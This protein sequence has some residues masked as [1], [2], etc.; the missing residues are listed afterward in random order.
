MIDQQTVN[1]IIEFAE[2]TDVVQ[3]FVHLKRRGVNFLGLCPFHNEKTPSFTVSPSKGI[4]KCFGC[5]KAGNAVGFIMDH[6]QLSYPEALRYLAKKYHIEITE[7]ESSPEQIEQ[8]NHRDSMLVLSSFAQ[9]YFSNIL[10]NDREGKAI[11]LSYLKE[12]G[13]SDQIIEKFQLGYSPE[14]KSSFTDYAIKNGYQPKYLIDTGLTI[15][16]NDYRFD[17]FA[18]RVMFPIHALSGNTI[19]FGGRIL[20]IAENTAKYLNSPESEIY[21]KSDVLYGIYFAKRD[22]VKQDKCY[23]VEGYTDVISFHQAGI[24]N[25]V[26]SSG[27]S[28]TENQIRLVK[29]FTD[30]LTILYDGDPAGIKASF[31]GIDMVLE[32]GMNVKVVLFPDGEDPDSFSKKMGKKE[33]KDFIQENENDF[34]RFKTSLLLNEAK[35]DPIKKAGLISNIVRSIGVIPDAIIRSVYIKECSALLNVQEDALYAEI[36]RI[37]FQKRETDRKQQ[38]SNTQQQLKQSQSKALPGFIEDVYAEINEKEIISFLI[39]YGDKEL[40][41]QTGNDPFSEQSVTVA[42][43]IIDEILNDDLEFKNLIYK[44]IFEDYSSYY[45]KGE[46]LESKFFIN[47]KD[48]KI[49]ALAAHIFSDNYKPSAIWA[50]GGK[51]FNTPEMTL[52]EDV[53]KAINSYKLKILQMAIKENE[54]QLKQSDSEDIELINKLLSQKKILIE[55]KSRLADET[56][57]RIIF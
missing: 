2:I 16:K 21:H 39:T 49:R 20:K 53:P 6:E 45:R 42:A 51:K 43:F 46:Y 18:G 28:L 8:K 22:I 14:N 17:R 34:I 31:R 26:A 5:G 30:N 23:M 24:E 29:R 12:R 3:D 44:Q 57:E 32:Q 52:K 33:L 36:N 25:V 37:L 13:F 9:K 38:F 10:L 27:T 4:Y 1:K 40:Y 54:E 11:G 50:K 48:E 47:H 55:T 7:Q 15:E 35:D 56:G 41:K 19:A